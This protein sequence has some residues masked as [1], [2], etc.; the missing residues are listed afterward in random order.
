MWWFIATSNSNS[1]GV[2][3]CTPYG[4]HAGRQSIHTHKIKGAFKIIKYKH[5]KQDGM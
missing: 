4:M 2:L 5:T 1:R 3:F